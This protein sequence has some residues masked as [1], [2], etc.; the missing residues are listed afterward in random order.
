MIKKILVIDDEV[1][2]CNI[3]RKYFTDRGYT[4]FT[5]TEAGEG[6]MMLNQEKPDV[7][8]LDIRMPGLNGIDTLRLAREVNQNIRVIMLTAIRDEL[9][10][11][12]AAALGASVYMTKPFNLE[13]LEKAIRGG[14]LS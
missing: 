4:V 14:F 9:I 13:E 3:L 1:N 5:S 10:V 6:L 12:E 2:I 11:K 7:L 8:I